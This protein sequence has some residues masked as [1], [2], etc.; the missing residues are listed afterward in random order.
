MTRRILILDDDPTRLIVLKVRLGA[1]AYEIAPAGSL[2]EAQRH[3]ARAAPHLVI[4][5]SEVGGGQG[6]AWARRLRAHPSGADLPILVFVPDAAMRLDALRA[7]AS[8]VIVRPVP[9]ALMLA[10]IRALLRAREAAEELRLRGSTRTV[11]GL[12]EPMSGFMERGRITVVG[13]QEPGV[14]ALGTAIRDET[15]DAVAVLPPEQAIV[16]STSKGAPDVFVLTTD[17]TVGAL[18]L[19]PQLRA[20]PSSRDAGVLALTRRLPGLDPGHGRR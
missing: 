15:G 9:D 14:A 17:A 13:T 1:A 10:R 5:A 19:I 16:G 12:A 11:L 2:R 8:E 18:G 4:V 20:H 7:G 3:V 6:I